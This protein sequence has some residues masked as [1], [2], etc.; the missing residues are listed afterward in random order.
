MRKKMKII[1]AKFES[2][3][4]ADITILKAKRD[5]MIKDEKI[6]AKK[7]KDKNEYEFLYP[8]KPEFPGVPADAYIDGMPHILDG[9]ERVNKY[10]EPDE[11]KTAVMSVKVSD[12]DTPALVSNI[13]SHGGYDLKVENYKS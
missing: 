4:L 9:E 13:L 12:A 8:V 7:V 10:Y 2:S 11:D 5:F 3:E 1:T 6:T